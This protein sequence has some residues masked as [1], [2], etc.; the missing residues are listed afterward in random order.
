MAAEKFY[1]NLEKAEG[2]GSAVVVPTKPKPKYNYH[3]SNMD[4]PCSSVCG[5]YLGLFYMFMSAV[6]FS[7]M[8][9]LVALLARSKGGDHFPFSQLVL[10]RG[11]LCVICAYL[12][13]KRKGSDL[14]PTDRNTRL[15]LFSRSTV[16]VTGMLCNWMIVSEIPLSDATVIVF[17]APFWTSALAF[18]LLREHFGRIDALA[19]FCG[20]V[21]L[22]LV[23]RPSFL[24]FE[25]KEGNKRETTDGIPRG[26]V[27]MIGIFGAIASA[28]TN[29]LVRKLKHI[30]A[31]VTVFWLMVAAIIGSSILALFMPERQVFLWPESAGDVFTLLAMGLLGYFGQMFKTIGLKIENAGPGSMM[32]LVDLVF[33]PFW[34]LFLF[35][36][37][38][39]P[40]TVFGILIIFF[41][42][43]L[44]GYKK[45]LKNKKYGITDGKPV[46]NT[47]LEAHD[48][49]PVEVSL[50]VM[51][52]AEEEGGN[53]GGS[54]KDAL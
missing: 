33:A 43:F 49:A 20:M 35:H 30:D 44:V 26:L 15:L 1:E 39:N 9:M 12:Y 40:F 14:F 13:V 3:N 5:T 38:I 46:Q 48:V 7:T 22:I 36:E 24:G 31:M 8:S 25:Q 2:E 16:G 37:A 18:C 41:A 53:E 11:I 52:K 19:L 23:S 45:Y 34:Q 6:C 32:R 21:G 51:N 27:V 47:V 50:A 4:M 10:I 54:A 42:G 28:G 29:L 17:T